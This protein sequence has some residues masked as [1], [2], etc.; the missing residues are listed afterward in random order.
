MKQIA[1]LYS[2]AFLLCFFVG[3]IVS[4]GYHYSW[5]YYL[6]NLFLLPIAWVMMSD[7]LLRINEKNLGKVTILT[8]IVFFLMIGMLLI[9]AYCQLDEKS[10][11]GMVYA[12]TVFSYVIG[13]A[14]VGAKL[15]KRWEEKK[16]SKYLY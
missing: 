11:W 2:G 1:L 4:L 3:V 16:E 8:V 5:P 9:A 12:A 13:L 10:F 15:P 6:L 7:L 14:I